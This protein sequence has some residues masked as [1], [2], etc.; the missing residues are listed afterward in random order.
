MLAVTLGR[1]RILSL[2]RGTIGKHGE[3]PKGYKHLL[4]VI[5]ILCFL[6]KEFFFLDQVYPF[7]FLERLFWGQEWIDS[8]PVS[9]GCQCVVVCVNPQFYLANTGDKDKVTALS[10][11]TCR[12]TRWA[13][14]H[15]FK[16]AWV[17]WNTYSSR[18]KPKKE[19]TL[20]NSM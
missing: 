14:L 18:P 15:P 1:K 17:M 8:H 20:S 7:S 12:A 5:S 3:K 11:R 19:K 2:K 13:A 4:W 10:L 9:E 6:R 16:H